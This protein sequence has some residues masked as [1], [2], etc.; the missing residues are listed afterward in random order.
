[1]KEVTAALKRERN[2][3]IPYTPLCVQ[4][5]KIS[6]RGETKLKP[7][8]IPEPWDLWILINPSK[9]K[10]LEATSQFW[11]YDPFSSVIW[12]SATSAIPPLRLECP[13]LQAARTPGGRCYIWAGLTAG[14]HK[15]GEWVMWVTTMKGRYK[16]TLRSHRVLI[17]NSKWHESQDL[18]TWSTD[19]TQQ[20]G[21]ISPSCAGLASPWYWAGRILLSPA[22]KFQVMRVVMKYC[23]VS[24]VFTFSTISQGGLK[25]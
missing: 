19:I 1:M 4:G 18:S 2:Y 10:A 17:K 8:K 7:E 12:E 25:K 23:S 13:W 22:T 3:K 14:V 9:I 21:F 11:M 20:K 24:A 15:G 6:E 16:W 5:N